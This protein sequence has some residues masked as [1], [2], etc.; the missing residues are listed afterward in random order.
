[1]LEPA[2]FCSRL[3]K[4]RSDCGNI[5]GT[6]P[7]RPDLASARRTAGER[8]AADAT[9]YGFPGAREVLDTACIG[10]HV[11][12]FAALSIVSEKGKC[13]R[14]KSDAI[15]STLISVG[16]AR[17]TFVGPAKSAAHWRPRRR[18]SSKM[19]RLGAHRSH[20]RIAFEPAL[21]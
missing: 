4:V 11:I 5:A 14:T 10:S 15:R 8:I 12:S 21:R 20:V 2:G 6:I 19:T 1:M 3:S 18:V 9:T 17:V 16:V 13:L 7:S